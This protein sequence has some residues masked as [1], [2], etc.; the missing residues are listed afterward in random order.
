MWGALINALLPYFLDKL[1]NKKN[2]TTIPDQAS[3][4]SSL[5][6]KKSSLMDTSTFKKT[7]GGGNPPQ[8]ATV[9]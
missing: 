5:G 1:T 9:Y 6:M 7:V 3:T 4:T 8:S 2:K